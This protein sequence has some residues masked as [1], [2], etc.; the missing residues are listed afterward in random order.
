MF[1]IKTPFCLK[2]SVEKNS[3]WKSVLWAIGTPAMWPP[4]LLCLILCCNTKNFENRTTIGQFTLNTL[5]WTKTPK[6]HTNQQMDAIQTSGAIYN[7]LGTN[8]QK[9]S[10]TFTHYNQRTTISIHKTLRK[11]GKFITKNSTKDSSKQD[12]ERK[13][14]NQSELKI[15]YKVCDDNY[16]CQIQQSTAEPPNYQLC[17]KI[18]KNNISRFLKVDLVGVAGTK[19]NASTW[20][21]LF[22]K[23]SAKI[24][25]VKHEWSKFRNGTRRDKI[26]KKPAI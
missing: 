17:T 2:S 8:E 20:L 23:N 4:L 25:H 15:T 24:V 13:I 1:Q 19:S 26:T 12:I 5:K 11:N 14:R 6:F 10:W 9:I 21:L 3:F 16:C 22:A 7:Q 18:I